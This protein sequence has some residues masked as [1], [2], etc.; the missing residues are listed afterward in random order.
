MSV[1]E[2]SAPGPRP[3]TLS[4]VVPLANGRALP[5]AEIDALRTALTDTLALDSVEIVVARENELTPRNGRVASEAPAT[6]SSPRNASTEGFSEVLA[7]DTGTF[8]SLAR[9]GILA[10]AGDYVAVID[11]ERGYQPQSLAKSVEALLSDDADLAVAF[12]RNRHFLLKFWPSNITPKAASRFFFGTADAF[13]GLFAFRRS[14]WL[15]VIEMVP[16]VPGRRP[17]LVLEMLMR[18]E[19]R[20]V[21]VPVDVDSGYRNR[22]FGPQDLRQTKHMLDRRFGNYSRLVQFCMVGASGMIIDLASYAFFQ[23]VFSLFHTNALRAGSWQLAVA[24]ILAITIALVWNFT[25]NRTL[26]FN[27]AFKGNIFKQFLTYA[28]GNA[29]AILLSLTLR[30]IL[31]ARFEFFERHRLAAALV[32]IVAGTGISF[33][34]ARWFVFG[35]KRVIIAPTIATLVE[36]EAP[37]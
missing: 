33:A 35:Q 30:L 5:R 16:R 31:P 6:P 3:V 2:A 24:G 22:G 28:L 8:A 13:S 7:N 19:G 12:A 4:L 11:V 23:R 17:S 15:S 1:R 27:D 20:C 32:G 36:A 26:T 10:A 14:D 18:R 29:I 9:A 34:T 21:D 37:H 25:L